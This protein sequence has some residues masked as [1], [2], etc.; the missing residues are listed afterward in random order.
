MGEV[1]GKLFGHVLGQVPG[2]ALFDHS[3]VQLAKYSQFAC[4]HIEWHSRLSS[5]IL[6]LVDLEPAPVST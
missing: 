4:T 1:G 6:I 3:A 2:H 5:L